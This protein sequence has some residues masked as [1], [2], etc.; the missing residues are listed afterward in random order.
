MNVNITI[1][2]SVIN[3]ASTLLAHIGVSVT[4]TVVVALN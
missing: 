4:S 3:A 1:P 2:A